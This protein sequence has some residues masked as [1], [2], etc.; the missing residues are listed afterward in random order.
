[1]D[2]G[3]EAQLHIAWSCQQFPSVRI[4]SSESTFESYIGKEFSNS[5]TVIDGIS[6]NMVTWMSKGRS[7]ETDILLASHGMILE[8]PPS[9][10]RHLRKVSTLTVD[11]SPWFSAEYSPTACCT[12]V[13][14]AEQGKVGVEQLSR[15]VTRVFRTLLVLRLQE[16]KII[17]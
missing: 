12:N 2:Q 1:M 15:T 7:V 6:A 13:V 16:N 17:S 10:A 3:V 14:S 9:G 5:K 11:D 8:R 4:I